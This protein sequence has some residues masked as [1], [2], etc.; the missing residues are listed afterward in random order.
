MTAI[1]LLL[2]PDDSPEVAALK[3]ACLASMAYRR[4]GNETQALTPQA[5]LEQPEHQR[6]WWAWKPDPDIRKA[7]YARL[8]WELEMAWRQNIRGAGEEHCGVWCVGGCKE[9][10]EPFGRTPSF[11]GDEHYWK[12]QEDAAYRAGKVAGARDRDGADL[13]NVVTLAAVSTQAAGADVA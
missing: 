6:T 3:R 5:W 7:L 13:R 1:D 4:A 11:L 10:C 12:T 2:D 8:Q 9:T